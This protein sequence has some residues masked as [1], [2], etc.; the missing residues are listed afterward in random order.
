[1]RAAT[2]PHRTS[3]NARLLVV[4]R[5]GISHRRQSD[6]PS[7]LLPGDLVVANDAATLPASLS[8]LH[9]ATGAH[10]EVRL[11]GRATLRLQD[12]PT[13]TAVIFGAGD[14]HTPTEHRPHPPRIYAGDQLLLGPLRARVRRVLGH[15]RLIE[16]RFDGPADAIWQGIA[17]HGRPIQYAY[18]PEPLAI[19]DTWTKI[20]GPPVAFEPPS[21]GFIL[22]WS[23]LRAVR[24]RGAAFATI[25]HAAG[26]SSTGDPEL[27]A[28]LPLDEPYEIPPST[29]ALINGTRGT[30]GRIFAIGTT[31]VRALESAAGADGMVRSGPGI[32]TRTIG[33]RSTLHVVDAI[34]SGMHEPGTSH[35]E[36]LKAFVDQDLLERAT[37]EA[38]AR[39]YE[40]H[41]FGDAMV[42]WRLR[43]SQGERVH[44][45]ERRNGNERRLLAS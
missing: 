14:Y 27:D 19:W 4:D 24:R 29:A 36:L 26:I 40:T 2:R 8:G 16:L 37:G 18:V 9:A 3:R 41:E 7:L 42:V 33:P 45:G 17:R 11:A 25:T 31:V 13:F 6:V 43:R 35:Y 44:S 1:M 39:G 38:E 30:G 21:A 23:M 20:A 34:A 15:P 28:R 22:D 12:D 32:A 5:H 10:I